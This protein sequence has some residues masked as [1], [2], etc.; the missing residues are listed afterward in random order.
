MSYPP[1]DILVIGGGPAGAAT[2]IYAVEA[3]YTVCLLERR[4]FPRETLC[5]EFLSHEVVAVLRDLGLEE[6]F[7]SLGPSRLNLFTL[8]PEHGA[9][10]SEPL[11]FPAFGMKRGAF[12]Q[13]LLERA[14]SRGTSILQPAEV[15]S[16][17]RLEDGIECR[18]R[19]PNG[20]QSIRGRWA[21][22]AYG[23]SSPLD[24]ALK[25]PFA[26]KRT[27][28]NGVKVHVPAAMLGE[29]RSDEIL[30]CT[31]PGMYCGI[32]HVD[33]G[34]ATICFL[35]QRGGDARNSR[36]RIAELGE[37]NAGFARI[38]T[39]ATLDAVGRAAIHGSGNIYFGPRSVVVNGMFMVGDAARVIAPVAGDGIG[40][41]LQGA[42]LLG[43]I[44]AD[45]RRTPKGREALERRYR[46]E[47]EDLFSVR[48]RSA[49]LVQRILLTTRLRRFALPLLRSA[50][51]VL[52]TTLAM[53]RG[54]PGARAGVP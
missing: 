16:V 19:T 3:G 54:A 7:L 21:I 15:E 43:R 22:G 36:E 39:P 11:G 32:N 5:G 34:S 18:C 13:M 42:Q 9:R 24:R 17:V 8:L 50:P 27:R 1:V 26:G 53:T 49:L 6:E 4:T 47:W 48:L 46:R 12:D 44:L 45:E 31:G 28:L 40:M 14:R 33:A 37:A 2:A 35:E 38:M 41:A 25:R 29:V 23:R 52:R 30:I 51:M 10:L 20:L